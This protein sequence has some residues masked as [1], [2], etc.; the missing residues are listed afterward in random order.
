MSNY[1]FF[2]TPVQK[3]Q[4][5]QVMKARTGL[6]LEKASFLSVQSDKMKYEQVRIK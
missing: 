6:E 1:I 2:G 5:K 3:R 4:V